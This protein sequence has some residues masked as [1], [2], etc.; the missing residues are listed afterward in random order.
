MDI[1]VSGVNL[2]FAALLADRAHRPVK[3]HV[4]TQRPLTVAYTVLEM[5][6]K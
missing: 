6:T 3:G 1:G 5:T 2:V 4:R